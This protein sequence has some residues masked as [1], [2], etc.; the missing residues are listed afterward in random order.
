MGERAREPAPRVIG[1][2][3]GG[4][5]ITQQRRGE[6][7]GFSGLGWAWDRHPSDYCGGIFFFMGIGLPIRDLTVATHIAPMGAGLALVE[8]GTAVYKETK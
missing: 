8:V 2:S 1:S 5:S 4:P 6:I 3:A 7:D